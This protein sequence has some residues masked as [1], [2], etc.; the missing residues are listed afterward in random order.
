MRD[1]AQDRLTGRFGVRGCDQVSFLGRVSR[2]GSVSE[3]PKEH[4]SK[5]CV[6]ESPPWVQIPPLP[7]P[8]GP[9]PQN[10]AAVGPFVVPGPPSSLRCARRGVRLGLLDE[11]VDDN[12]QVRRDVGAPHGVPDGRALVGVTEQRRRAAD[13]RRVRDFRRHGPE[14]VVRV[15]F[16]PRVMEPVPRPE[17]GLRNHRRDTTRHI[18]VRTGDQR[19]D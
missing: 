15:K 17:G 16:G 19:H 7:P 6:G 2:R 8:E 11:L 18:V 13:R 3:R 4:A 12:A 14:E 5:A 10:P 1:P 9:H